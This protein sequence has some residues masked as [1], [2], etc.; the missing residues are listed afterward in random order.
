MVNI[1]DF[2]GAKKKAAAPRP[3][4]TPVFKPKQKEVEVIDLDDSFDDDLMISTRK[5]VPVKK[6]SQPEK[7]DPVKITEKVSQPIKK[8]TQK[9]VK[10]ESH[11]VNNESTTAV[12]VKE[13]SQNTSNNPQN[14]MDVINSLPS[15]DLDSITVKEIN[16]F[17]FAAAAANASSSSSSS[18]LPDE[19]ADGN[20]QCLTGLTIV[21]T[22]QLPSLERNQ[23]EYIAKFYGARVTKSI[24]KKTSI[25]ILGADAGPKKIEKIKD[26][27]IKTLD[28][29]NFNKLIHLMP[30]DGLNY[31]PTAKPKVIKKTTT[32]TNIIEEDNLEPMAPLKK[33]NITPSNI[34]KKNTA[35]SQDSN[36]NTGSELWTVKY[37]PKN[38]DQ[39]CGNKTVIQRLKTWLSNWQNY[40]KSNFKQVSNDPLSIFRSAM[41]YGPPGIGKTTTAHLIAKELGYD[42]L[43]QNASDVRSKSLLNENVK[44]SLNNTSVIGL[45]KSNSSSNSNNHKF[46]IIMDEVDGMSGGDRGGVGQLAKFCRQTENPMILICNERNLP[47]MKPFDRCCL[48]LQFRRPT[49]QQVKARLMT[50]SVREN[51]KLDP[52]VIDRLVEITRSDIRQIINL[53]STIT[54]TTKNIDHKNIT[55]ISKN[56]EKIIALKPFDITGKLLNGQYYTQLGSQSFN[57]NDKIA[58]YFD[59]FDFTPLMIQE[60]YLFTRPTNLEKGE[61]HLEAIAKA[62]ESISY[63]D[64]VERKIRS[65][66]QLWSLLPFH[67]IMSSIRPSS[68]VSGQVISR[69][70]FTSW[71]GQNSKINKYKR[72]LQEIFYHMSLITS[73]D[74]TELAI[75]YLPLLQGKLLNPISKNGNDGIT[76][77]IEILD[78][79]YLTKEDWDS[80]M[81]LT[82][83]LDK[84][85]KIPTSVKSAFTRKYNSMIHPIAIYKTG[86]S[87]GGKTSN[88][89][90][91][92]DFED[93]V[94]A[95][96]EIPAAEEEEDEKD[97]LKKDK[98]IKAKVRSTKRKAP[99]KGKATGTTKK[100]KTMK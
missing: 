25:V 70:N 88:K 72:I 28:E 91:T 47:K 51:F 44:N 35:A 65:T 12:P 54:K 76:D 66:D 64:L 15:V 69:I 81:D 89:S 11:P 94:D 53:L 38:S 97:D 63:G 56:W 22:G 32:T 24:S 55:E 26:L 42:I 21:F 3:K 40:K 62:S 37:A 90:S 75:D 60:N 92:P 41:I 48:E 20:D 18:L 87:F 82:N 45:M 46:V 96:D 67:A 61:S 8:E 79:Y 14:P 30:T 98:L 68:F 36:S 86:E 93:V 85:K 99:A 84:V 71:L 74:K 6:E 78:S 19:Y 57:L 77:V 29:E 4:A 80:I 17:N 13:K 1:D 39:I 34:S 33:S 83:N 5:P 43:E 58:L 73:T 7:K 31:D 27:N 23:A 2:F 52:L 49:A 59:D 9:P 10:K 50:I 100:R 95:D 16:K